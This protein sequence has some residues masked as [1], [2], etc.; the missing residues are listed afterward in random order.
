[1]TKAN[2][3]PDVDSPRGFESMRICVDA[4]ML[5]ADGTGVARYARTLVDALTEVGARPFLLHAE[6]EEGNR[7]KRWA[8]SA[9]LSSR[10][11]KEHQNCIVS[12]AE[13]SIVVHDVFREAQMHFD[14]YGRL[15][16][17]YCDGPPGLM[18]WTYPIPVIMR[19]WKNVYTIHD[20]I[21]L[22]ESQLSPIRTNRHR[23]LL[24]AIARNADRLITVSDSARRDIVQALRCDP[25]LVTNTSQA[26]SVSSNAGTF[27][28][29]ASA[30]DYFLFCGTIEPRKNLMR[31]AEAYGQ[32]GA[33]R[34]LIIVGPDGWQGESVRR[35]IDRENVVLLPFQPRDRLIQLMQHA[36]AL[37]FPSLSEGFGLPIVEAMALGTPVMTSSGGATAEVAGTAALLVDPFDV[38]M[39]SKSIAKLDSDD[40]LC[41]RLAAAGLERSQ[42]FRAAPYAHRVLQV[43][44]ELLGM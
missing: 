30:D 28:P 32:S 4:R 23:R 34:K 40:A 26:I 27:A 15:M 38:G 39:M 25:S 24:R 17:I 13:K 33:R 6:K 42:A 2:P 31:L 22:G 36:R 3:M 37:L 5:G 19:G 29:V 16:P 11:A 41:A 21:P 7:L 12:S 1:M 8:A 9:R 44:A 35:I 14:M 10:F 18:H 20:V 43:Y